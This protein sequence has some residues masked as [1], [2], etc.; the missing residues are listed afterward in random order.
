MGFMDFFSGS[1]E[2][3]PE[4]KIKE[5]PWGPEVRNYL[6]ELM[7]QD[8][9]MPTRDV[10]GMSAAEQQ[11]QGILAQI[12]GGGAFADPRTSP[13]YQGLRQESM[14]EE[15]RAASSLKRR[16]QGSGMLHSSTGAQSEGR[17]RGDYSNSR[18]SLLGGLY[19][20]ERDRDNPYSRLSAASQYGAL[21]RQIEQERANAGYESAMGNVMFPYQ[22]QA[23]IAGQLLNYQPW[24][25]PQQYSEPSGFAQMAGPI[26]TIMGGL[27]SLGSGLGSLGGGGGAGGLGGLFGGGGGG[28]GGGV[29]TSATTQTPYQSMGFRYR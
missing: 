22:Q 8:V 5:T 27:G 2:T 9:S 26:G 29:T 24:Y 20:K 12:L 3:M 6:M 16:Q 19:E 25:Q 7:K 28:G 15:E 18:M 21:P 4:P 13:L 10:A 11:G 14:A 17:L 23:G 1:T